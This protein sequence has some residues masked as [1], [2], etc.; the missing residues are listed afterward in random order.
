MAGSDALFF[1]LSSMPVLS[2]PLFVAGNQRWCTEVIANIKYQCMDQNLSRIP[3]E[4]PS[5]TQQL[6]LSFNPLLILTPK[7]F[8]KFPSLKVLDLTRCSIDVIEDDSFGGLRNLTVLILTGN[9]L[10][11]LGDRA[12]YGLLS[13]RKLSAV[14]MNL[15][16]LYDLPIENLLVL[17]EL[18]LR[19]NNIKSLKIPEFFRNLTSLQILDLHSNKISH[20][21]IEDLNIFKEVNMPN[22]TIILSNNVINHI[23]PGTFKD[24]HIHKLSLRNSFQSNSIMRTCLH[25]LVGL[26]VNKLELGSFYSIKP[27][28]KFEDELLDG[29]CQVEFQEVIL[30]CFKD[31]SNEKHTL[32]DCLSNASSIRIVN[33]DL[34]KLSAIPE[35]ARLSYLELKNC[36]TVD[37]SL[38]KLAS[39]RTLKTL[40]VT[41]CFHNTIF[42]SK[43]YGQVQHVSLDLTHNQM[44]VNEC[45]SNENLGTSYLRYLNLS[46]NSGIKIT[47]NFEGLDEL[48]SLD[49]QYTKIITRIGQIPTFLTLDKLLYLDLSYTSTHFFIQCAFC[50]LESLQVLKIS[51][52]SFERNILSQVFRNLTDLKVLDISNCKIEGMSSSAFSDLKKLQELTISHNK[53]T[54]LDPTAYAPLLS[55]SI[56][57]FSC[58]QLSFFPENALKSLP[59]LLVNLDISQNPFDCSCTHLSFL[60]WTQKQKSVLQNI[61]HMTCFSPSHLNSVKVM[62]VT[63]SSCYTRFNLTPLAVSVGVLL[64]AALTM[65]LVYKCYVQQ[66]FRLVL[67]RFC[68]DSREEE[69]KYDAFVIFSSK[70]EEWVMTELVEK[71]ERGL[72]PFRLCLHFRDFIP[73][74]PIATNIIQEGFLKSRKAIVIISD[75]FMESRWCGFE[76]EL[77]QSWQFLEGNA[78]IIVI[79]LEKVN[80]SQLRQTLGLHKYLRRNTYL[81]WKD[82]RLDQHIFWMRLRKALMDGKPWGARERESL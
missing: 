79:V 74:I 72:P 6:D 46:F 73:G 8:A 57:D 58:N 29:L 32:F 45:C 50:G 17:R 38:G 52:N 76:F 56:L 10:R 24:I 64:P 30:I 40:K 55:L 78:G 75:H 12:F 43:F 34:V 62:N 28:I 44:I 59:R 36:L 2:W 27:E 53:L 37:V 9:P 15:S 16:S 35:F 3:A 7:Y 70:D 39:W 31:L 11:Y 66:Y 61:Q 48:L 68:M 69:D 33:F 63:I 54:V 26:Q 77:A 82:S 22:L 23:E 18:N 47:S 25:G 21:V 65:F 71:L 67:S 81:E 14:D 42:I 1:L 60:Q 13:L 5:T 49:F 4:I 80:K 41:N 20:I 19:R 51:G